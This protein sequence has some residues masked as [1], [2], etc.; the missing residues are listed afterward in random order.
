[1]PIDPVGW[2]ESIKAKPLVAAVIVIATVGTWTSST[3]VSFHK[4]WE[5][6]NLDKGSQVAQQ[7][8]YRNAYELGE[9]VVVLK[10]YLRYKGEENLSR[11]LEEHYA[12]IAAKLRVFNVSVELKSLNFVQEIFGRPSGVKTL[13]DLI[14]QQRSTKA[15]I[16]FV[17]GY[18]LFDFN[19]MR[20]PDHPSEP[21][22]SGF[23]TRTRDSLGRAQEVGLPKFEM[24]PQ[25]D[26]FDFIA[27]ERLAEY[28]S[29]VDKI[30]Y[31]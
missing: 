1:M 20:S 25:T 17:L 9:Q 8:E 10:S 23:I 11:S 7:I 29:T 18:D 30:L 3:V 22:D 21:L 12:T 4:I 16:M 2:W 28:L 31:P 24:P 19:T 26:S 13:R 27:N 14:E 6:F 5:F 15:A